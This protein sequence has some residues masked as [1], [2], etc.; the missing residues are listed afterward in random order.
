M[1]QIKKYAKTNRRLVERR[2]DNSLQRL[3]NKAQAN[4]H[5]LYSYYLS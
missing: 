3:S 1:Q 5:K 4:L 2:Y